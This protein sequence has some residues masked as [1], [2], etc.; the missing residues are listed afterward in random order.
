MHLSVWEEH[1]YSVTEAWELLGSRESQDSRKSGYCS[2]AGYAGQSKVSEIPN[3]E[4]NC[5][6]L[7]ACEE[8]LAIHTLEMLHFL[9]PS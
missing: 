3:A 4:R 7:K 6:W 1:G 2:P 5:T 8:K 9:V